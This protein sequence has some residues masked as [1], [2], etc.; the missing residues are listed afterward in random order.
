[1]EPISVTKLEPR[2][3]DPTSVEDLR[4]TMIGRFAM[5]LMGEFERGA[6]IAR[7]RAPRIIIGV[8]LVVNYDFDGLGKRVEYILN[9]I[10]VKHHQKKLQANYKVILNTVNGQLCFAAYVHCA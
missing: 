4:V 7:Y 9:T 10:A 6:R 2:I 1:M 8:D 5:C 3:L